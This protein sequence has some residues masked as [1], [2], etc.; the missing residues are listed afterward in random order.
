M[1]Q[2]TSFTGTTLSRESTSLLQWGASISNDFHSL[3][4][5]YSLLPIYKEEFHNI[6]TEESE[7][8]DFGQ[9]LKTMKVVDGD[10]SSAMNEDQWEAASALFSSAFVTIADMLQMCI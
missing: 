2:S 8:P 7:D 9:L 4:K 6:Y 3:A 5:E 10:G 1:Y